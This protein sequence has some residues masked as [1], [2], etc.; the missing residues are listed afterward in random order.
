ME[1]T[2]FTEWQ[3]RHLAG[4]LRRG[5]RRAGDR[6]T[7]T[8]LGARNV[9]DAVEQINDIL[10]NQPGVLVLGQVKRVVGLLIAATVL[11]EEIRSYSDVHA[12]AY[13]DM[14]A[15][16]NEPNNSTK[17]IEDTFLEASKV[18]EKAR[19]R[20]VRAVDSG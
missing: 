9:Q 14:G 8:G 1:A 12:Q 11:R 10:L 4:I 2:R 19:F 13:I 6:N 5:I 7:H 20:P 15:A 16:W 3:R 17:I 18:V